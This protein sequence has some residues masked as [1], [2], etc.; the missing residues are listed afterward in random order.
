[1]K[2]PTEET[3]GANKSG[4]GAVAVFRMEKIGQRNDFRCDAEREL[5]AVVD[6]HGKG[7]GSCLRK[8]QEPNIGSVEI[9]YGDPGR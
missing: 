4:S 6:V 7:A 5:E 9:Y 8:F 2:G 3:A 1:M